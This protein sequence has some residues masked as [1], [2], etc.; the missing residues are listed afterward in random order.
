[1]TIPSLLVYQAVSLNKV[2]VWKNICERF[3][4]GITEKNLFIHTK[5][6]VEC[7]N[8][9]SNKDFLHCLK[10]I[11]LELSEKTA[12]TNVKSIDEQI[13]KSTSKS[14]KLLG[15]DMQRN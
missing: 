7:D 8:F 13:A 15:C 1:M 14:I 9:C 4:K 10:H 12:P 11:V 6:A 3:M 2:K 5:N